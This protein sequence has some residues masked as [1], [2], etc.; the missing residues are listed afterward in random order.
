MAG[1]GNGKQRQ[2]PHQ[3]AALLSQV[4]YLRRS[5]PYYAFC[6]LAG[7]SDDDGNGKVYAYDAIGSY[8]QVAVATAGTGRELLQPILDRLFVST[9]A[10]SKKRLVDGDSQN[11]VQILCQAYRSVSER[12]IG[13][14][15]RLVIVVLETIPANAGGSAPPKE[16]EAKIGNDG[17]VAVATTQTTNC[18]VMVVP[19]KQH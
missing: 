6:V 1:L 12:E 14:G 11:A 19:L 17:Q 4:L 9:M 5:F 13:V 3:V 8:E 10:N 7:L 16:N 2:Q 15:D 18:R